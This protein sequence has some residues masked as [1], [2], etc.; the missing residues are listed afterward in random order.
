[1]ISGARGLVPIASLKNR[2][3]YD[4]DAMTLSSRGVTFKLGDKVKI[5]VV[6]ADVSTQRVDFELV[7]EPDAT[8]PDF[9]I[10]PG[11]RRRSR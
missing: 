3:W 11:A 8:E 2:Y 6:N 10:Y 1:M 9:G 5:R 7:N 4:P